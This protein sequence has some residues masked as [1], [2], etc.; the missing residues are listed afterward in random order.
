MTENKNYWVKGAFNQLVNDYLM[1]SETQP[2]N[3]NHAQSLT[4]EKD[5]IMH[6]LLGWS[7]KYVELTDLN[8]TRV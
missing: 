2:D 7:E 3:F 1:L 4:R 5:W 6:K 8:L